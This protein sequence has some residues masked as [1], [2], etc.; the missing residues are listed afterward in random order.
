MRSR[1][2]KVTVPATTY[3]L[4]SLIDF[5]DD[6]S[7]ADNSDDRFLSRAISICSTAAQNFCNRV[8]AQETVVE[9]FYPDRD[10]QAS[11]YPQGGDPVFLSRWPIISIASVVQDVTATP[12]VYLT[13]YDYDP[14]TGELLYLKSDGNPGLWDPLKL[15]VTYTGGFATIPLDVQGAITRMVYSMYSERLRDPLIKSMYI[16]GI[17]RIEYI[18]GQNDGNLDPATLDLLDNY[19]VPVT[20]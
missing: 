11:I 10:T 19:R 15:V 17:E 5:K 2:T 1:I 6:K 8:F 7:I 4:I 13:D 14:D 9:T 12:L 20:A 18:V 3:D 16:D